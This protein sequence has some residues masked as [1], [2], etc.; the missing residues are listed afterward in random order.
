M[1]KTL[2]QGF[3]KFLDTLQPSRNEHLKSISHKG[4]ILKCLENH[5]S[6]TSLFETGSF[7][8]GTGVRHFSDTDYF[9]ICPED[10]FYEN[11][12]TTLRYIKETLQRTFTK[13]LLK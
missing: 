10:A 1:A 5:W 11:S 7:G 4:S 6:R 13:R 8:N 3:E 9:A 2:S 12:A